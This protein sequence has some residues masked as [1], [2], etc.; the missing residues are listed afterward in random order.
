MATCTITGSVLDASETAISG[1]TIRAR[2]VTPVFSSTNL[3]VPKEVT[4]TSAADGSWSLSLSRNCSAIVTI[5]YPPNS[6]D[7]A[8]KLNYYISVPNSA[9][10]AF[11][12]LATESA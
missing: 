8:R 3:V 5:E 6:T 10:S 12:T 4:T 2:I 11:S 9:S 7:S 1:A